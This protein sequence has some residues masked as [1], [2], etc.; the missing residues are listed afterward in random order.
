MA[1]MNK[2][3]ALGSLDYNKKALLAF[4]KALE[5]NPNNFLAWLN[6]GIS[7]GNLGRY[8]DALSAFDEGS[9]LIPEAQK[10]FAEYIFGLSAEAA[11]VENLG[12]ANQALIRGLE[13]LS[14]QSKEEQKEQLVDYF[15]Q[16]F[17]KLNPG[18]IE[19]TLN[20]VLSTI[21]EM[22]QFLKPFSR[23]LQ[24]LKQPDEEQLDNLHPEEKE[25]VKDIIGL[26]NKK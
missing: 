6:K 4:E 18:F 22:E 16:L 21:P 20:R 1:W 12:I 10:L 8:E 26:Q 9:K 7:Q 17:Q 2:G 23:A 11:E 24:Y 14:K 5:L 15:K 25:V 13:C 3:I 19:R